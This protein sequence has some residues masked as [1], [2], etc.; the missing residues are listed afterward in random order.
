MKLFIVEFFLKIKRILPKLI[1][2]L[3]GIQKILLILIKVLIQKYWIVLLQFLNI[4]LLNQILTIYSSF[5]IC[6]T[7]FNENTY[8][9]PHLLQVEIS[10]CSDSIKAYMSE[11]YNYIQFDD[12]KAVKLKDDKYKYCDNLVNEIDIIDNNP[13]YLKFDPESESKD[14]NFIVQLNYIPLNTNNAYN[15]LYPGRNGEIIIDRS[16]AA[17]IIFTISDIEISDS[18]NSN[19]NNNDF[20][21][22]TM[23][24]WVAIAEDKKAVSCDLNLQQQGSLE[25]L[26]YFNQLKKNDILGSIVVFT[27]PYDSFKNDIQHVG[28]RAL[29]QVN[30]GQEN[31]ANNYTFNYKIQQFKGFPDISTPDDKGLT[32]GEKVGISIGVIVGTIGIGLAI[33]IY[34]K[35]RQRRRDSLINFQEDSKE[36]KTSGK[37]DVEL[38]IQSKK[39]KYDQFLDQ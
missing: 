23:G 26:A 11:N 14:N 32:T 38:Y 30:Y 17:N 16:N 12:K 15:C 20:T 29:V 27:I 3:K 10:Q 31:I 24:F 8:Q 4:E 34:I 21:F 7:I 6:L 39:D 25:Y 18:C 35:R 9:A 33:W 5:I 37:Q 1:K 36:D 22:K 28:V 13:I 2:L 19:N